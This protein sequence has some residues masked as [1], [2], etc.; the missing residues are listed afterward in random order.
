MKAA[1]HDT[2]GE[3][4]D[5]LETRE[6][7]APAPAA[8]E[9]RVRTLLSPIHNHDL[10]TI[11]GQYGY[12]PTLPGAIGGTEAAG[13]IEAVGNGVDAALVGQRVA[14]A[15]VHGTWAEQFIAPAGGVLPLPEQISDEMGAQLISMP[16]SAIAL[17]DLLKAENGD[18][19]IQNAANGAVGRVMMVLAEA[20]GIHLLNLV[21]REEAAVE[22]RAAGVS[23]VLS[24]SASDWKDQARAIIGNGRAISAIDSVG[25]EISADMV[26]LLA[27]DGEMVV[28]GTATGA[29]MPLSSGALILKQI[30]IR[31]FWG[32]R[33][34]G[35][36]DPGKRMALMTEL[37]TLAARG[38][39]SLE[40]G[41]I[42][43]LDQLGEAM[44]A[45]LTPGRAG[46]VMLK[47]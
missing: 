27:P 43:A 38:A 39:L 14:V 29:P 10:W 21:R 13:V 18:W 12:K 19:I 4:K 20:R 32:S 9:V 30:T 45:S 42:F 25:G 16:F 41:G 11:R 33:V 37:V 8:D 6:V 15:G 22:L 24:T 2:F 47:P 5:V 28:F 17:L 44:E 40:T 34:S 35:E 23:H 36:M 46:K 26:D 3:P 31:G 7:A 1:V